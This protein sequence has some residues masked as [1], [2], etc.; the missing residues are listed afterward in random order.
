[1]KAFCL[2]LMVGFSLVVGQTT[3]LRLPLLQGIFYD[4]LIPLVVFLGLHVRDGRGVSVVVILGMIMDL[5]SGGIFGLYLSTYFWIF[6][7]VKSVSKYFNVDD[8]LFQSLLVGTCVLGQHLVFCASLAPPWKEPQLLAAQT[9]PILVQTL[10]AVLT[11]PS[12]FVALGKLQAR[13][14][15]RWQGPRRETENFAAR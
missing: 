9:I 3:I 10:L 8:A 12:I 14:Q 1:M 2:Y 11:G 7:L 4:L 13:F 15:T 5:L 6:L